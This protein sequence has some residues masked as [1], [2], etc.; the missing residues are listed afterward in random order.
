MYANQSV[1]P[2]RGSEIYWENESE[3]FN[4][5]NGWLVSVCVCVMVEIGGA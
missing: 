2:Q 4:Q 1:F 3:V 5:K